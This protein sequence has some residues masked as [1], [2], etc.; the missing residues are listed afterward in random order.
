MKN[1]GH[2]SLCSFNPSKR[3]IREFQL[4][5]ETIPIQEK[6]KILI[7]YREKNVQGN[8]LQLG[9]SWDWNEGI[10]AKIWGEKIWYV[11]TCAG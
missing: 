4:N 9:M 2:T 10:Q 8:F 1:A 6:K 5:R 11:E 3:K 7:V